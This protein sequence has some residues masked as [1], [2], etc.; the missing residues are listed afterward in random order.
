MNRHRLRSLLTIASGAISFIVLV[1]SLQNIFGLRERFW[2]APGEGL[3]VVVLLVFLF[4]WRL[5]D[6]DPLARA[7][8]L[9]RFALSALFVIVLAAPLAGQLA[10]LG[11]PIGGVKHLR[12]GAEPRHAIK[13]FI[14]GR[15]LTA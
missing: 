7:E 6:L 15:A 4:V 2:Q 10:F 1:L 11:A 13:D 14:A 5:R 12:G 3:M 8:G 9:R